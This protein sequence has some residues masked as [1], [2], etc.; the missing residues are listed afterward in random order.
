MLSIVKVSL[1]WGW[2]NESKLKCQILNST[3]WTP[4]PETSGF[5]L[6]L[7]KLINTSTKAK[8]IYSGDARAGRNN[9]LSYLLF[10]GSYVALLAPA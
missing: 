7:T 2:L 5:L 6:Q 9:R 1:H 3:V 10:V 8:F 4:G